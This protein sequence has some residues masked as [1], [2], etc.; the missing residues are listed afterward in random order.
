[1]NV[2]AC[3]CACACVCVH[4]CVCAC[5][6]ACV[7]VRAC[8]CAGRCVCERAVRCVCVCVCLVVCMSGC[9]CV[10]W[11]HCV[12]MFV[13]RAA[14]T[15]H[16]APTGQGEHARP[17]RPSCRQKPSLHWHAVRLSPLSTPMY[18][19]MDKEC[20]DTW[21]GGRGRGSGRVGE[22]TRARD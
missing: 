13:H 1:V 21:K 15:L 3:V 18:L 22:R 10:P 6:C 16:T 8:V 4:V 9:V 17:S 20:T 5:E 14:R 7:C 11:V 19:A 12:C 2:C